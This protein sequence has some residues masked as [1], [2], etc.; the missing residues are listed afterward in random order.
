MDLTQHLLKSLAKAEQRISNIPCDSVTDSTQF[1]VVCQTSPCCR[2]LLNNLVYPGSTYMELGTHYGGG[3]ASALYGNTPAY[4]YGFELGPQDLKEQMLNSVAKV[5]TVIPSQWSIRWGDMF[6]ADLG[7]IKH[8]V[9]VLYVDDGHTIEEHKMSIVKF[10]P[11]LSQQFVLVVDDWGWLNVRAGTFHGLHECK[12]RIIS[13][14]DR[15]GCK[16]W[17]TGVYAA[18][19]LK[20]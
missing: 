6:T 9:D 16:D 19:V 3:L 7:D 17:F 10:W 11:V 8:L 18:H 1:G 12:A 13:E 15:S 2:H 14:H 20:T 4:A 5:A